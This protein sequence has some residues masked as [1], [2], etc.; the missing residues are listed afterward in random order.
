VAA[1]QALGVGMVH[2][3]GM[4]VPTL[5]LADNAALGREPGRG[6]RYDRAAAARALVAAAAASWGRPSIPTRWPAS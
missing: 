2:Q 5:S 6:G 3:H 1:A 4:L